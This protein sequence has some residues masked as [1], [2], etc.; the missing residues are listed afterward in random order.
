MKLSGGSVSDTCTKNQQEAIRHGKG[1][2]MVLAGP[3][4]GKTFVITRRIQNLIQKHKVEPEKILVITFS[5]SAALEMKERFQALCGEQYYPVTFGT[6][7]AIY[8]QIIKRAYQ[9]DR[10]H[11]ITEKEKRIYI[12][13]ILE[14]TPGDYIVDEELIELVLK[15]ISIVKNA[16]IKIA[17][18]QA[19][20]MD[21][22]H[23]KE[24]FAG[25]RKR[26]AMD[27]KIDFDD[28]VLLTY[29]LFMKRPDIAAQWREIYEYIL[30][31]EFQDINFIQ[32]QVIKMLLGDSKNLFI[33][34]DDDQSIYGFRGAKPEIMLKF[35]DLFPG[36]KQILLDRNFRSDAMIVEASLAVINENKVRF[37]KE[38]HSSKDC[39]PNAV[40]VLPFSDEKQEIELICKNLLE[41]KKKGTLH[42]NAILFR[43]NVKAGELAEKLTEYKIPFACKE[44]TK[45]I[46][47]H[48]IG[49][50]LFAYLRLADGERTRALFYEVMNKPVRYL[51]R[52]DVLTE[53]V[54]FNRL[55]LAVRDR[56]YVLENVRKLQY[57]MK[58]LSDMAPFPALIYIRKAVGYDDYVRKL[59]AKNGVNPADYLS[60]ADEL[61]EKA[62]EFS[63]LKDWLQHI[64][65]Y[66]EERR[67]AYE[68]NSEDRV[69]LMTMHSS[70][71]LEWKNV[72]I[73]FANEGMLPS[74]KAL[75]GTEV[76]EE[77]RLFY[78]AMT[79]A[80]SNLTILYESGNSDNP[81]LKS[82]FLLPILQ[83]MSKLSMNYSINC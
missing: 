80:K 70:K 76:E 37:Y 8:F 29:E 72:Y 74:P 50:D 48:F 71:G 68:T 54:D 23:F 51:K 77:R 3:G 49:K 22:E 59:A 30:I 14:S 69:T 5:K 56:S 12:K 52:S 45:S 67:R 55:I 26:M 19:N 78:V 79:R 65:Q 21:T 41:E 47:D 32:F 13:E 34:G 82:R 7:H 2:C 15:E 44:L 28:M 31:D 61:C 73:P 46:Y 42:D 43:M 39:N 40:K 63:S 27:R 33:V 9:L 35:K 18:Y 57:H 1:P 20:C 58:K 16:G 25:Y 81:R 83:R 62:K 36:C 11:I 10:N 60:V 53:E 17:D 24:V 64:E 75:A 38:I 6:F 66:E 4:S